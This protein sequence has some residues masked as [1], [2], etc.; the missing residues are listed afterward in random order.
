MGSSALVRSGIKEGSLEGAGVAGR[1]P[2]LLYLEEA[3]MDPKNA[4]DLGL[5]WSDCSLEESSRIAGREGR[6]IAAYEMS[7]GSST[8]MREELQYNTAQ[9]W[10]GTVQYSVT[11]N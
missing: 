1:A 7:D 9:Q 5:L 2:G 10:C 3:R 11:T 6:A 8:M 4:L